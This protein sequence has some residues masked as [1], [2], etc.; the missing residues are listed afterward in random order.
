M[1][2]PLAHVG[3]AVLA[4]L[5]LLGIAAM[6]LAYWRR[7]RTL[8]ARGKPVPAWRT[9]CFAAGIILLTVGLASP[10]AHISEELLLAHMAQHL[11]IG[12]LAA[13]LIVLGLT[14]PLLQPLLQI[15]AIDRLRVLTHP[16][17]ALPLWAAGPLPLA[18]PGS[19]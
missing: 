9:A 17:V 19:L 10:L 12:D 6:A 7:A 4:P 15:S 8:A 3:G 1:S 18:R 14:A 16:L 13:L 2:L 11:L 5:Q